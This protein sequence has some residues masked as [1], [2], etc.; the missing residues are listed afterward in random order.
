MNHWNNEISGKR[1]NKI[2]DVLSIVTQSVGWEKKA[3]CRNLCL[4]LCHSP[5]IQ[6]F[7][8]LPYTHFHV[9]VELCLMPVK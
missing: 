2:R 3:I 9:K 8:L 5:Q 6:V 7:V 4:I 1:R